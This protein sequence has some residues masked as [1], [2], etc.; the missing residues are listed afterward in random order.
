MTFLRWGRGAGYPSDWFKVPFQGAP[1]SQVSH[2]R[3]FLGRVPSPSFFHR[4]LVPCHFLKGRASHWPGQDWGTRGQ[5][6]TGI[7]LPPA[8]GQDWGTPLR[9]RISERVLA[10]RRAVR[11]FRSRGRTFLYSHKDYFYNPFRLC[12]HTSS[13]TKLRVSSWNSFTYFLDIFPR[14]S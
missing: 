2:P 7:P 4:S 5:D 8:S 12:F 1:H 3:S 11:L 9:D 13:C 6:R 10:T 14:F